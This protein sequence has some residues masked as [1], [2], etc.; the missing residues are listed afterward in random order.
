MSSPANSTVIVFVPGTTASEL[1]DLFGNVWPNLVN[2][3][4]NA[5][6]LAFIATEMDT[7]SSLAV[8]NVVSSYP[9]SSSTS[10]PCY[11][12]LIQYMTTAGNFAN[13]QA[14]TT[15][16]YNT[17]VKNKQTAVPV[18]DSLFY[19][20]P[21]DWRQDNLTSAK[22]LYD[23]ISYLDAAYTKKKQP[24]NLYLVG[25]SMGGLVS[26]AMLE[27]GTA[28]PSTSW[29]NNL[30]M[31][32][33]LATPHLGAPLALCPIIDSLP[34]DFSLGWL[35]KTFVHGFVNETIFPSTYELLPPNLPSPNQQL[36]VQGT[37]P[38][39]STTYDIYDSSETAF[40]TALKNQGFESASLSKAEAF[41]GAL[42]YTGVPAK[43]YHCFVGTGLQTVADSGSTYAFTFDGSNTITPVA[44]PDSGDGVVPQPSATFVTNPNVA[45]QTFSLYNHG[46]M[47]GSD[48]ANH[49]DAIVAMLTLA[50]VT[51]TTPAEQA[52][53]PVPA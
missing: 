45:V 22:W 2:K 31:L 44:N 47:G 30:Q 50:G 1:N 15:F 14:F 40:Q 32:I 35:V 8:G 25:H 38:N 10:V 46:Q 7:V 28:S 12:S 17:S 41:F 51:V 23:A 5:A 49:P 9:T 48:M 11:A 3:D 37:P 20:V 27:S 18:V 6:R 33:T 52:A 26:R 53:E 24:Y 43:P 21:Y 39:Q 36:F 13:D 16:T 19:M 29:W 34:A 4:L 42:S